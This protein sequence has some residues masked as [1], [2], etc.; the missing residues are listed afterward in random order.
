MT[1]KSK[2]RISLTQMVPPFATRISCVVTGVEAP[3]GEGG[4]D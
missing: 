3:G 2:F 4:N 1:R